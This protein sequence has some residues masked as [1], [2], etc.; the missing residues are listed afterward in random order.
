MGAANR[1][2]DVFEFFDEMGDTPAIELGSMKKL[3][4]HDLRELMRLR[5]VTQAELARRMNTSRMVVSRLL[6]EKNTGAT[7]ATIAEAAAALHAHTSLRLHAR[8]DRETAPAAVPVEPV[9]PAR[10]KT[11]KAAPARPAV[12]AKKTAAKVRAA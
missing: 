7:L 1:G 10:A 6:D 11:K 9:A 4:V 5:G 8:P 12:A 3:L 2:S